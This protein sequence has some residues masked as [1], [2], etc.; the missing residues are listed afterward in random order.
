MRDKE[1]YIKDK[2]EEKILIKS[3]KVER[4]LTRVDLDI[5]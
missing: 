5:K 3:K 4:R 1:E 2:R